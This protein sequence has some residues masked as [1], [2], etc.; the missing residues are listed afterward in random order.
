M[1]IKITLFQKQL[2]QWYQEQKR[3]LPWRKVRDPYQ[4]WV[5]EIMLQQTKV[6]TA[7]P[8]FEKF[9]QQFPTLHD[10]AVA[11]EEEVLKAWEGLGYY[12]RA[13]NLHQG[14]KEVNE[15][16]GGEVPKLKE[17]ILTVPGIGPY[18]AGAILSIAYGKTEP[19]VDGNVLRV[20]SRL[21]NSFEDVMKAKTKK[22]IEKEVAHLIPSDAASDF[23]QSIMEL[24]ATV[25]I[26]RSPKCSICPISYFC[27]ARREGTQNLLPIKNKKIL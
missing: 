20:F 17:Q 18:T 22:S 4:I 2:L 6:E 5:S 11:K 25:C 19:A 14:V 16:Y 15:K 10:L 21:F 13:R 1:I 7:I 8:Y 3:D 23:N 27:E 9:I 24:G 26:P 12:S